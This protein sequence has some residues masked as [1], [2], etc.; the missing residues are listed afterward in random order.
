M[1]LPSGLAYYNTGSG[2]IPS[3]APLVFSFKLYEIQRLDQDN[4]GIPSFQ[5][6]LNN[7][8]YVY[9]YTNIINFPTPPTTN[10]DDTDGDK[11]PDFRDV[12]DDGDN[13]TTRLET[14]YINPLD[15]NKVIR[16]YPFDGVLADD[17]TTEFVDE[18]QG[19]PEYSAAGTP[20]FTTPTRKRIHLDKDHHTAKP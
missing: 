18:R 17:L 19:I 3:Y 15:P 9:D 13:Y 11:I 1:F 12:D 16:Y 7:D 5:E 4:D 6:D 2:D 20:D 14:Q 10:P 8:G